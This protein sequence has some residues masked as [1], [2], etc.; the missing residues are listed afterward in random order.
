MA[1]L[2]EQFRVGQKVSL[3]DTETGYRLIGVAPEEP[4]LEIIAIHADYIV[5]DDPLAGVRTRVPAYLI[6]TAPVPPPPAPMPIAQS[7]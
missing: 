7:A 6:S 2:S 3:K 5:L 4:G 1:T